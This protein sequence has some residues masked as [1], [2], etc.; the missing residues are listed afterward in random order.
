MRQ[1]EATPKFSVVVPLLN[2][3]GSVRELHRQLSDV[4]TGRFDPVEFIFVDDHSTDSTPE[5]LAEL[6]E[7]DPRVS[8]FRLKRNYG[9]TIALAAG[10]DQA[11]GDIILSMDGDLQHD[12]GDIPAMLEAMEATD[13]DIVS[14]WRQKRV[15]NFLFRRMPSRIANW[16]MAKLS[17][18]DIHD[19]GTT[20]KVYRRET[21]KDIRLYGELHRFIPALASWNGAKV[22]EVAIRNVQRPEG[23]SHYGI[24]RTFRVFFDLITILFLLRYMTRPLHFFG[25]AGVLSFFAGGIILATLFFQKV[26]MGTEIFVQHGPLLILGMLLCLFGMQ[27]L[28]VGLVGELMTRNYFEAHQKPVYRIERIVGAGRMTAARH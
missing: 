18:V 28:A 22:T 8:F 10:F 17:G 2:E 21:I 26:F 23:K 1:D 19:F 16:L 20:F 24:S 12:P 5:I 25:P 14:G 11:S 3:Q 27:F 4:M 7:E 9:Q 13:S 15:D 6:A